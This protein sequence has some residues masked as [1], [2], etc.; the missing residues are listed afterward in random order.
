MIKFLTI[1]PLEN[2]ICVDMRVM[3]SLALMLHMVEQYAETLLDTLDDMFECW[4]FWVWKVPSKEPWRISA[5][6]LVDEQQ[7]LSCQQHPRP[8]FS[9]HM[10]DMGITIRT[11]I[12]CL[13]LV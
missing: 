2:S 10:W 9:I 4:W 7:M 3:V 12:R 13:F 5:E 1:I 11:R 6:H 8:I